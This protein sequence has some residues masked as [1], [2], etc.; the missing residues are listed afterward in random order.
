MNWPFL[1]GVLL[2]H[3]L[4]RPRLLSWHWKIYR[5]WDSIKCL[6]LS[7]ERSV[8]QAL[9]H[10]LT[11]VSN[12]E[13]CRLVWFDTYLQRMT[14]LSKASAKASP[15]LLCS[16][17]TPQW[18]FSPDII[19]I[20]S[21]H[22]TSSSLGYLE[23]NCTKQDVWEIEMSFFCWP[24]TCVNL[25]QQD[26]TKIPGTFLNVVCLDKCLAFAQRTFSHSLSSIFVMSLSWTHDIREEGEYIMSHVTFPT[27]K[28]SSYIDNL[29]EKSS[30]LRG[31]KL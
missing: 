26:T 24:A 3:Y 27:L 6:W 2:A 15:G 16:C 7:Y 11:T 12:I 20:H 5:N 31:T 14:P 1:L 21:L 23:F 29:F 9:P 8:Q 30:I 18:T 17:S 25:R 10:A 13:N 19:S 4:E 22:W 28:M